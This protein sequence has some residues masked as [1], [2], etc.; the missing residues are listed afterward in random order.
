MRFALFMGMPT[1]HPGLR[2]LPVCVAGAAVFLSSCAPKPVTYHLPQI[3][4]LPIGA[5]VVKDNRDSYAGLFCGVLSH[6]PGRWSSCDR[7]LKLLPSL[8][9]ATMVDS[10]DE[11]LAGYRVLL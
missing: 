5:A 10:A 8:P 11:F 7:Y 2:W 6:I 1:T 3:A 9:V 4:A